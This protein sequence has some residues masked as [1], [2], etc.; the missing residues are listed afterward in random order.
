MMEDQLIQ[1]P[2]PLPLWLTYVA[3][4]NMVNSNVNF[5][6]NGLNGSQHQTTA[7]RSKAYSAL[8]ATLGTIWPVVPSLSLSPV[9]EL[10]PELI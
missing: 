3:S 9:M 7:L 1:A 8:K 6:Y 5:S 2:T 10:T 4:N